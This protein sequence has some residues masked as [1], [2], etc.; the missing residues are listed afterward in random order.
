M[1]KKIAWLTVFVF[2]WSSYSAI[3]LSPAWA[4]DKVDHIKVIIDPSYIRNQEYSK[5]F[6]DA[7]R[8]KLK[9]TF[10]N[11]TVESNPPA[12]PENLVVK[13]HQFDI[14]GR[15]RVD[16]SATIMATVKLLGFSETT[17][18]TGKG[19][20]RM[21]QKELYAHGA[22][23]PVFG[24]GFV[25]ATVSIFIRAIF[26]PMLAKNEAIDQ[27][28]TDLCNKINDYP[29]LKLAVNEVKIQKTLPSDLSITAKFSDASGWLFPNN[30]M[31]AAEEGEMVVA[32][33][34]R[35]K[36][37][38]Y[39]T[40]LE[41]TADASKIDF[42][43]SIVSGDIPPGETK[44]V[45]V[46]LKAG[47]DLA[48]GE[49]PFA[50]TLKEKRGYDARKVIY[51]LRTVRLL[52]PQ[53]Q[54]VDKQINDG[55]TGLAKG[56]GNGIPESGETVEVVAFIKNSGEG[57]AIGVTLKG[58]ELSPGV[59]WVKDEILVGAIPAGETVKAKLAFEIPRNYDDREI[60][61]ALTVAD[62]R[63]VGS[64]SSRLNLA[65]GRK[66]PDLQYAWKVVTARG[67][68]VSSI[69]N[70]GEYE[71]ELS[72]ANLGGMG[73]RNVTLTLSPGSGV[74]LAATRIDAGE[75]KEQASMPA[76]RVRLSL[77]RT[78][79]ES[80]ALVG[81][82]IAQTDF[83]TVTGAI[84]IPV[85]IK[86]PRLTYTAQMLSKG[87]GNTI[88]Q[89]E[90]AAMLEL[91]VIN[92][93]T[94]PSQ[95]VR[96]KIASRDENLQIIGKA[97]E[98]LGTVKQ[99]TVGETVKFQLTAKRKIKPGENRLAV[100]ITQD[101]FPAVAIPYVLAIREE[102]AEVIQVAAADTDSS[103]IRQVTKSGGGPEITIKGAEQE[104]AEETYRLAFEVADAA[105]NIDDI[106]V[107]V[108]GVVIPL[109]A[110][111][112]LGTTPQKRKQLMASIPLR[113]GV[114]QV[115]IT[116]RNT[117]Y[118][119]SSRELAIT[120]LA[121]ED[122]DTPLVT[123]L[124]NSDAVAVVVGI[125]KYENSR[126]PKADFAR[127]DAE[128]VKA[129][130]VKTFGYDDK[131]CITLYDDEAQLDKLQS[132]FRAK[133][134]NMIVPGKSDVFIYYSGHGVPDMN[135]KEPYLA[136][137]GFDPGDV[138]NT[139]YILKDLYQQLGKLQARSITVAIDSCYSGSSENGAIIKDISPVFLRV[140]N[141]VFEVRNS[142]L[143]T[144]AASMQE[145]SW[146]RSK[147][148]GLFTYYF[149]QGLQGNA[150]ADKDGRVTVKELEEHVVKNVTAQALKM[151]RQQIPEVVGDRDR[152]V[153]KL[154]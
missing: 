112:G 37:A 116:A 107:S 147:K 91:R 46:K 93:G 76:R 33:T 20:A 71:L 69:T 102:R 48:D 54:I 124:R 85:A 21:T 127:R 122:V 2:L 56:N 13:L 133:I 39:G 57:R 70:G 117:D 86:A 150:D 43:K 132:A 50:F 118:S 47:H 126:V 103:R 24:V 16:V 74:N 29:E 11:V 105:R 7:L 90:L 145:A 68:E 30:I 152:V 139:G 151:N 19:T 31:D 8:T 28:S 32:I 51:P 144:A 18:A 60:A 95:G 89:G 22:L 61:S 88:E 9:D 97:E 63:G 123:G 26:A 62:V 87:G 77:P 65:Y 66:T 38:G 130:L 64:G 15:E 136:P 73:A 75:I 4:A 113:E 92:E 94:L 49:T 10:N 84:S 114:N 108:N 148:H 83:P 80:Q 154:N 81:L 42:D 45:R 14:Q 67:D 72:L 44:E 99:G 109:G 78:Y 6:I 128:T 137:Y 59:R 146:Y 111:S 55:D 27:L 119:S 41:I 3:L 101:D 120:R 100:E 141:P 98:M 1:I 138:E 34:N 149:L 17:S 143:F 12:N 23:M 121:E 58:S 153:V 134:R 36:G 125:S 53:L 79:N 140:T 135:S 129:Y 131:R 96:V 25:T 110:D 106:K 40:V 52:K 104:T 5:K 82:S 142:A 115:L 35:G